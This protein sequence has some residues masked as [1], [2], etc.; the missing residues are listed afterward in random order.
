MTQ[1]NQI[2]PF[3]GFLD[4]LPQFWEGEGRRKKK[5]K[6]D[7]IKILVIAREVANEILGAITEEFI[8]PINSS[9]FFSNEEGDPRILEMAA[10]DFLVSYLYIIENLIF[11]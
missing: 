4:Q 10:C 7:T 8:E 9:F 2:R 1:S 6:M 11:L 3:R 5:I